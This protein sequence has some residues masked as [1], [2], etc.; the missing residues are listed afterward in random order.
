MKSSYQ[1]YNHAMQ[2]HVGIAKDRAKTLLLLPQ[3]KNIYFF[4]LSNS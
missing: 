1:A 3:I 2:S 4:N